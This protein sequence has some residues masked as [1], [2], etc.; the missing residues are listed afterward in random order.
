MYLMSFMLGNMYLQRHFR[1]GADLLIVIV[2]FMRRGC[3]ARLRR[4][5][6][7]ATRLL[8]LRACTLLALLLLI[9][10]PFLQGRVQKIRLQ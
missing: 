6:N 2:G 7:P 1:K 5:N 9:F 3:R 4:I 8:M 10:E